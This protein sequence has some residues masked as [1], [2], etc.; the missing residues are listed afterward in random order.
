MLGAGS[1]DVLKFFDVQVI[2]GQTPD[3]HSVQVS[4]GAHLDIAGPALVSLQ[5][6]LKYAELDGQVLFE[7]DQCTVQEQTRDQI[8]VIRKAALGYKAPSLL[9]RI[10]CC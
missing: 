3:A 8:I 2:Y 4:E 10:A 6:F 1:S 9:S 5:K 7:S